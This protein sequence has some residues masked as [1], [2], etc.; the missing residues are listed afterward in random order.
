MLNKPPQHQAFLLDDIEEGEI[1][2]K[3][4]Y[5]DYIK[6]RKGKKKK[7]VD[8][9]NGF[10]KLPRSRPDDSGVDDIPND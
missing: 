7:N 2:V 1:V 3:S 6:T 5:E 9:R 4:P 10:G 8:K